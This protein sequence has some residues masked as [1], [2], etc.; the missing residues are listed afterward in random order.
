MP[1]RVPGGGDERIRHLSPPDVALHGGLCACSP[2][3]HRDLH[4]PLTPDLGRPSPEQCPG[5]PGV[6]HRSRVGAPGILAKNPGKAFLA[7]TK[8]LAGE[9]EENDHF[10]GNESGLAGGLCRRGLPAALQVRIPHVLIPGAVQHHRG[11]GAAGFSCSCSKWKCICESQGRICYV[12]Q[13]FLNLKDKAAITCSHV[14]C[15]AQFHN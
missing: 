7:K 14:S 9:Q 6:I 15:K 3:A 13:L 5:V 8:G 4:Y 1:G 10:G 11:C 2:W 12:K